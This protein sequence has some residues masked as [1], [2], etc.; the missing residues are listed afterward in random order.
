MK[1]IVLDVLMYLFENYMDDETEMETDREA[2]QVELQQAGFRSNEIDKAFAWLE[3]LATEQGADGPAPPAARSMRVYSDEELTRLDVDARGFLA[4]LENAGL[5]NAQQRERVLD[6]L[7]ALG[8]GEIGVEQ[9][10]WVVLMVMFN[11]PGDG[12]PEPWMDD[13]LFEQRAGELH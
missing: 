3:D 7:S 5:M 4:H 1:E 9:V 13:F 2:L 8:S 12:A 6:R 10:K 11:Q